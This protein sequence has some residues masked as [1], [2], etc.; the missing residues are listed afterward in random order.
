MAL[1][2][3]EG[4][5]DKEYHVHLLQSGAGGYKVRIEYGRRGQS[6]TS[7]EKTPSEVDFDE[8]NSIFEGLVHQKKLKGYTEA[9]GQAPYVGSD[10]ADKISG[11]LPQLLNPIDNEEL[12]K[13]LKDD[14]WCMQEKKDGKRL[15][16]RKTG[17]T[18]SEAINRKGLFIAV[19]EAVA[20]EAKTIKGTFLLD[21]EIIGETFWAFDL[22]E[23]SGTNYRMET[24][25]TR[26]E[27]LKNLLNYGGEKI[28]VVPTA[29][30]TQDRISEFKRLKKEGV[31]G[32]VFKRLDSIYKA[33]RPTS[34]VDKGDMLKFKFKHTA[35]FIVMGP[36]PK[37][38]RSVYMGLYEDN[39]NNIKTVGKVT[40]L[41]NFA[42]PAN[43][44]VV[45]VEYLYAYPEGAVYQP[46]YLGERDDIDTS[47][48]VMSQLKFKKVE[49]DEEE[50]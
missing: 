29:F 35:S 44:S 37:G 20:E 50:S 11:I 15:L 41:P 6:L 4:H 32:V 17:K 8:A 31:E 28:K 14:D 38:K 27:K 18:G 46:I 39:T 13:L 22:L 45:E 2:Y 34:K 42:V 23:F 19:S 5:S 1:Y 9:A 48:C 16:L 25:K 43:G 24:Y 47:A 3:K 12:K 40:V 49:I 33:G 26:Y 30:T 10:K 36:G 7:S 21:G